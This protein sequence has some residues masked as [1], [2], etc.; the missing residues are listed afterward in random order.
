LATAVEIARRQGASML[1]RRAQT[2]L[3]ELAM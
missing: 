3:S 2:S 1:E